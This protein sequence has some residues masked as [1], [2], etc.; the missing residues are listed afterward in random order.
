MERRL[1]M[2]VADNVVE[3]NVVDLFLIVDPNNQ[4]GMSCRSTV[5]VAITVSGNK[6]VS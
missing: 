3:E 1:E 4:K 6:T 5:A 2:R